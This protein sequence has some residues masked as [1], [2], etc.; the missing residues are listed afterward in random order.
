MLREVTVVRVPDS[1]LPASVP[2]VAEV[3]G[4]TVTVL[5]RRT[6]SE[7]GL[8]AEVVGA[9]TAAAYR[10]GERPTASTEYPAGQRAARHRM[11]AVV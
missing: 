2:A 4:G 7:Q 11:R 9:L 6:V 1:D 3:S 10:G 5:V 8:T